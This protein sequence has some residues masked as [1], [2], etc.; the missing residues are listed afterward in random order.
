MIKRSLQNNQALENKTPKAF[1]FFN[2]SDFIIQIDIAVYFQKNFM[3]CLLRE[4]SPLAI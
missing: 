1:K 2:N 3:F 4:L